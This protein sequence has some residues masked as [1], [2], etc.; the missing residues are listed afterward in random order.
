MNLV[1]AIKILNIK[2][3]YDINEIKRNYKKESLRYHPDRG[4]DSRKF[5][6]IKDAYDTLIAHSKKPKNTVMDDIDVKL[7]RYYIYYTKD[8]PIFKLPIIEKYIN[9]PIKQHLEQY[10]TY[11]ITPSLSRL[12]K[13]EVFYMHEH[14]IYI[15]LWHYNLIFYEKINITILPILPKNI[16]INED[17]DICYELDYNA[18]NEIIIDGISI[19][20]SDEEYK[21]KKIISKGIPRIKSNIYDISEIG[22]IIFV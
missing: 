8:K 15:P 21:N 2:D 3:I 13:R 5:I 17:N 10:K 19:S 16:S 14:D 6:L 7:L 9:R 12:L 1:D 22:D 18:T 4:G 11:E 20:F